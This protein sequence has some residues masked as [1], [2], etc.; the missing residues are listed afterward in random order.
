[1]PYHTGWNATIASTPRC[2]HLRRSV[3]RDSAIP[4]PQSYPTTTTLRRFPLLLLL[5]L[6]LLL[7]LPLLLQQQPPAVP[8]DS[9]SL[10]L[11]L[12]SASA[13]LAS[14][15]WNMA[16]MTAHTKSTAPPLILL[17]SERVL[18]ASPPFTCPCHDGNSNLNNINHNNH[19]SNMI[20]W[21]RKNLCVYARM[22]MSTMRLL[23]ST[24]NAS[25]A[26]QPWTRRS[27][28]QRYTQCHHASND[29]QCHHANN[30][31]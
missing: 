2:L 15:V 22:E 5:L 8:T 21:H 7:F 20:F 31:T 19:H 30:D 16:S 14:V 9:W 23:M 13:L 10:A 25:L 26:C 1:M 28:P 27:T 12:A 11:A 17:C 3:P 18:N 24:P 29:T 6:L 4:A